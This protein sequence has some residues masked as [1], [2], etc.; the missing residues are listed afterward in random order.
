[1]KGLRRETLINNGENLLGKLVLGA[2]LGGHSNPGN[3]GGILEGKRWCSKCGVIE[4]VGKWPGRTGPGRPLHDV[5]GPPQLCAACLADR[6]L[7]S[8]TLEYQCN[9]NTPCRE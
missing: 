2:N 4:E 3:G 7:V 9:R 1:V 8:V 5:C 6:P